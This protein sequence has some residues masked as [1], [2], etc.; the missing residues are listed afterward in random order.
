MLTGS[1]TLFALQPIPVREAVIQGWCLAR[2][3]VLRLLHRQLTSVVKSAWAKTS[4]TIGPIL[5][6]PRA[7]VNHRQGQGFA[8]DFLQFPSGHDSEI[9]ETD[10]IIVGS[11]CGAGV[12][13]KRVAEAGFRTIVVDR[14]YYWP[15]EYL[16]MTDQEGQEH[17]FMNGGA[18]VCKQLVQWIR[19]SITL[20]TL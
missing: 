5:G 3:P 1:P 18:V 14:S 6:F 12:C 16:P 10:V 19:R 17:M 9:I 8:F 13:A 15:P 7:P 2:L 4:P 11:G 20:L